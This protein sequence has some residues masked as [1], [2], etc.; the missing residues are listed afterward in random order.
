MFSLERLKNKIAKVITL[1]VMVSMLVTMPFNMAHAKTSEEAK[2]LDIVLKDGSVATVR[3][4]TVTSAH[5]LYVSLEDMAAL[6][7]GGSKCFSVEVSSSEAKITTGV[8]YS[9]SLNTPFDG[10]QLNSEYWYNIESKKLYIDGNETSY[11]CFFC[12]VGDFYDC[13]VRVADFVMFANVSMY[14]DGSWHL[15]DDSDLS[16]DINQIEENGF[17]EGIDGALCGDATTGEIFYE[18]DGDVVMEIASTTKLITY[19]VVMD[20]IADGEISMDD[21]V[22]ISEKAAKLSKTEDGV[23]I[24]EPGQVMP[25]RELLVAIMLPSSNESALAL[26]EHLCGSEEAFVER[27][28]EK[29]YELG[30]E[31]ARIYN[32]H[33]LPIYSEHAIASKNQNRMSP[34]DM[35]KLV[36]YIMNTYPEVTEITSMQEATLASTG[37]LLKNTNGLLKNMPEVN[38]LKTGTTNKAGA[39]LVATCDSVNISGQEHTLVAIVLGAESNAARITYTET[40]LRYAKQAFENGIG[41]IEDVVETKEKPKDARK[42]INQIMKKA[43]EKQLIQ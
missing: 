6:L 36:S 41:G 23:V 16:I 37:Q 3:A 27:M 39:C 40:L 28:M 4:F 15:N 1:F 25:L 14:F 20:A 33:G 34:E 35:F 10:E 19:A 17:F 24:Y 30:I 31:D 5:E 2:N 18:Y 12:N 38:G 42:L 13:Y 43:K 22:I 7:S 21:Q 9:G 26:A 8:P 29:L 32:P 11:Q